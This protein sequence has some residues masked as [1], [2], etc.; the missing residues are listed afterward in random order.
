MDQ[1]RRVIPVALAVVTLSVLAGTAGAQTGRIEGVL[2][3]SVHNKPLSDATVFIARKEPAQPEFVRVLISDKNGRYRIDS[4]VAGRY[5]INLSHTLLDSIEMSGLGTEVV[6]GADEHVR[7]DIAVPSGMTLRLRACRGLR[8]PP[9]TGAVIGHVTD[10]ESDHPLIGATVVVSWNDVDVDRATL[11]P[12]TTQRNGF[13][14][15]DSSGVYRLCGVPTGNDLLVQVQANGRA[16]SAL[17]T[18][19]PEDLG[20]TL[21]DLSFSATASRSL[22]DSVAASDTVAPPPLTGT[23]TIAGTV[24]TSTGV[25]LTDVAVQVVDAAGATRTD[26]LGHFSLSGLPAGSQLVEARKIGYL[27]GRVPVELRSGRPT[28]VQLRLDRFVTLDSIKVIAQRGKYREFERNKKSGWGRFLDQKEI[29][30]RNVFQT[31]QIF[32]FMPGF[33][34]V[35]NGFEET[36]VSSRGSAFHGPCKPNVVIDGIPN[37]DVNLVQPNDIGAMEVYSS[38]VGG[39]PGQNYGCGVIVIWTKR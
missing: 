22:A 38:G 2:T 37:Q 33:R 11:Q 18:D 5:A 12:I 28:D 13:T 15:V 3:D 10:A 20:I 27:I 16:G 30:K 31:S 17:R 21:L 23:A 8:L 14:H 24:R 29:E 19:V 36:V 39:P 6:V 1:L 9:A 25:P 34:V 7:A 35:S 32:H 26:S 4:L